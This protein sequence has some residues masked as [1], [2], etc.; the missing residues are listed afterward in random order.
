MGWT[1]CLQLHS[2]LEFFVIDDLFIPLYPSP[3]SSRGITDLFFFLFFLFHLRFSA[4]GLDDEVMDGNG[5]YVAV[6]TPKKR[7]IGSGARGRSHFFSIR[8]TKRTHQVHLQKEQ[9]AE[10]GRK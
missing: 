3:P 1:D 8:R 4:L 9:R 7:L 2:I 10:G 6:M 5:M